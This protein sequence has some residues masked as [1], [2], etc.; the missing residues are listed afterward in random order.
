M[1]SPRGARRKAPMHTARR[2]SYFLLLCFIVL[3]FPHGSSADERI[4]D[5]HSEISV[6]PDSSMTVKEIIKVRSEGQEIKR[7]IYREFPTRYSDRYGNNY[8]IGF[9]IVSVLRD[10]APDG[11]HREQVSNGVRIYIGREKVFL[12]HGEYT[13]TLTYS[14]DRQLGFFADHDELY[15]NVTGNGWGFP[16][17]RASATIEF[18][19]YFPHDRF[20]LD[21]YTGAYGLRE[22]NFTSSVDLSGLVHFSTTRPLNPHEE[23]TIVTGWPKGLISPPP[24]RERLACFMSDNRSLIAGLAGLAILLCYYIFAWAVLGRDPAKGTIIPLYNPPAG[25]SPAAVRYIW[26]MGYDAKVFAAAIINMAVNGYLSIS[27]KGGEYTLVSKRTEIIRLSP[28]EKAVAGMIPA[29]RPSLPLS[30]DNHEIIRGTIDA[31][32]SVLK[33][34][35]EKI[36]FITNK[37]YFACGLLL[38]A[39]AIF[40]PGIFMEDRERGGVV[41]FMTFWLAGWSFGVAF[42]LRMVFSSWRAVISG[43]GRAGSGW[44]GAIFSA[45][46]SIPF[47]AGEAMGIYFLSTQG[48]PLITAV[49]LAVVA[50][51]CLFYILVKAPTLLGRRIM[52]QVEGFRV[53][54]SVAEGDSIR[55]LAPSE[56]TP[57]LFEKY[58]PYALALDVEQAWAEKFSD[59][60]S[61]VAADGTT[62]TPV[63]YSGGLW[64]Y[65]RIGAFTSS[66][67]SSLSSSISSSAVAPGSSSGFGGGGGSGGGGGGGGGGGW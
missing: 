11:Y 42:L 4:L 22:K 1:N 64:D 27:E 34:R 9:Q 63:W 50:I 36:Y 35:C 41:L 52:D 28:E 56:K 8:R 23:L 20:M 18:P 30:T 10:G 59:V 33:N 66:M 60:L 43:R 14:T 57:E 16:I 13:Y 12:P 7:G 5:F 38:S 65:G 54:L 45:I 67:G 3:S 44:G 47:L 39:I 29:S 2:P 62:Y 15:W 24:K 21:A 55:L 40:L 58:L 48:S 6:H 37:G 53:F 49:L 32:K 61:R 46:F 17:D 51:D 25:L 26:K 31:V 19:A